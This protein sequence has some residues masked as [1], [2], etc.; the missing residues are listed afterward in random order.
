MNTKIEINDCVYNIHPIYD[1][2]GAD[3]N[4][5]IIN[6]INKNPIKGNINNRG[7]MIC[8]VRKHAQ[9]GQKAMLVHR[10]VWECFNGLIPCD[11]VIDHINDNTEDNRLCNLKLV[12]HQVNCKKSAKNRD[13]SFVKYNHDNKRCIKA[14]N[15]NTKEISYYKSMYKTYQCLDINVGIIKMV[16]ENLNNCKSGISKK[17]GQRYI[18]EYIK[19]DELPKN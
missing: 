17:D 8:N 7:Y 14:I 16:C 18:F 2:Y 5:Y 9:N 4:G 12:T 13:Y 3:K 19:A 6:I 11:K 10:F 1:L 15:Q